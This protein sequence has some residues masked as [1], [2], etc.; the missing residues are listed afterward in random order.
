[1]TP[2][3]KDLLFLLAAPFKDVA[4]SPTADWFCW[5][6]ALVE[7]ALAVNP[8]WAE[9]MVIRRVAFPRPRA[10]VISWVGEAGQSLPTL[11]LSAS[12]PAPAEARTVNGL[13]IVQGGVAIAAALALRLGGAGPHP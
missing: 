12:G 4:L 5:H 7:G 9:R 1:M 8:H 3:P 10:E 2:P 6:C 13:N 11:I